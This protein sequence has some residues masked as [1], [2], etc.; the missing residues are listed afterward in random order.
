M[1]SPSRSVY[2][3]IVT[4]AEGHV[5]QVD[6]RFSLV[7]PSDETRC[8]APLV[9][10]GS[11]YGLLLRSLAEPLFPVWFEM[12]SLRPGEAKGFPTFGGFRRFGRVIRGSTS[13]ASSKKSV[14]LARSIMCIE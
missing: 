7:L 6:A 8:Y 5:S 9:G 13:V 12:Y 3:V 4:K 10:E 14:P 11:L 1:E 2:A